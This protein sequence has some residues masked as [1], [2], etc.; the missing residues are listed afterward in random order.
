MRV[1]VTSIRN[2][3][4]KNI[5]VKTGG[6]W[7]WAKYRNA[8]GY[9][10]VW[11][12]GSMRLA[13]RVSYE[14][15]NGEIPDKLF[16]LHKCD[17]PSCIN[18]GHLFLGTNQDNMDDKMEKGRHKVGNLKGSE[19]GASKLTDSNVRIIKA[20][21]AKTGMVQHNIAT[22]FGVSDATISFIKS[23]NRWRHL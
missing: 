21:L 22:F 15:F 10:S 17:N 16:V 20:L 1:L 12:K 2:K 5:K 14:T 9:G 13:H 3:L 18:P 23:G 6:C 19:H 4:L 11:Y 7:E 8:K